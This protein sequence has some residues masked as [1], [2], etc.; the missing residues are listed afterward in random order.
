MFRRKSAPVEVLTGGSSRMV[1]AAAAQRGLR[2]R[3]GR[4][5]S[6]PTPRRPK[7]KKGVMKFVTADDSL[8]SIYGESLKSDTSPE[9]SNTSGCTVKKAITFHRIEIREYERTVGDNPSCSSGP[10]IT[11][12]FTSS[13]ISGLIG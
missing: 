13:I 10:P 5:Q 6:T 7:I 9:N 11:Y 3:I 4:S 8:H 1:T 12:V 2:S